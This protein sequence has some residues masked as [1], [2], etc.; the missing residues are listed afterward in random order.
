M[1]KVPLSQM[2]FDSKG[3]SNQALTK[4]AKYPFLKLGGKQFSTCVCTKLNKSG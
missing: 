1:K 2:S 3:H 4:W